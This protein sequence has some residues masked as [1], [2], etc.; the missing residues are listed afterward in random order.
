MNLLP[1]TWKHLRKSLWLLFIFSPVCLFLVEVG[2]RV[3]MFC[4]SGFFMRGDR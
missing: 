1:R 4:L 3:L 2:G